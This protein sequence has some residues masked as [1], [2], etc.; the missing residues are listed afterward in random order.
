M[1]LRGASS[2]RARSTPVLDTRH[3][4]DY[5]VE[6]PKLHARWTE[7]VAEPDWDVGQSAEVLGQILSRRPDRRP[8]STRSATD[9]SGPNGLTRQASSFDRRAVLRAWCDQLPEGADI[10]IIEQLANQTLDRPTC[11]PARRDHG[12]VGSDATP[13][14]RPAD[15]RTL[16]PAPASPPRNSSRSRPAS[17]NAE[18]TSRRWSRRRRRGRTC[19][20]RSQR[21]PSLSDEQ[22]ELV[23]ALTTSRRPVD[24]LIAAAGTG[25]TFSLDAARDA[26]QRPATTSS[27]PPSPPRAAAELEATAG[28]PSHTI[29]SLLI[30]DLDDREHGN[31][32]AGT[33]L[34]VD[35]A[36][37]VGTRTTRPDPR[38]RR[39][40]GHEGR[41][42]R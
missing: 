39:R 3:A 31:L 19:S 30:D 26:W 35:E 34:I 22:V 10:T 15:R 29:A 28:I 20:T 37:M 5:A 42:R 13:D 21:V 27:A 14:D 4:K 32:R 25:K 24:V 1:A 11:S 36:G 6:P 41:A 8:E 17:S 12:Q 9:C 2:P 23:V 16:D 18:S 7:Q 33:V 40:R 38:P